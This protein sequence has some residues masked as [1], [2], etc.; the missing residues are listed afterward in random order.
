MGHGDGDLVRLPSVIHVWRRQEQLL[1][2]LHIDTGLLCCHHWLL[3]VGVC[4]PADEGRV[5]YVDS[6]C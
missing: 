1:Q 5:H 3:P 2:G 6:G 4:G